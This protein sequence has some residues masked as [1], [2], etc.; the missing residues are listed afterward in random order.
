MKQ[1]HGKTDV[2]SFRASRDFADLISNYK[3]NILDLVENG[4][5]SYCKM[6]GPKSEMIINGA[7]NILEKQKS[8]IQGRIDELMKLKSD[9]PSVGSQTA[10]E[11][12]KQ[13]EHANILVKGRSGALYWTTGA[14][15]NGNGDIFARVNSDDATGDEEIIFSVDDIPSCE[16]SEV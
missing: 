2:M 4:L 15:V 13:K 11:K 16:L 9:I 7:I 12:P 10:N 1:K 8:E 14:M 3:L 5:L 6:P